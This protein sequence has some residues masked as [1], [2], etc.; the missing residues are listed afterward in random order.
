MKSK[1][2]LFIIT[3]LLGVTIATSFAGAPPAQTKAEKAT[4]TKAKAKPEETIPGAGVQPAAYFYT[5]KPYDE[6]LGG[7]VFTCR[8]Y[9]P[10]MNRWTTP[11]PSGFPDGANPFLY[12]PVPT[13]EFD[14]LGLYRQAYTGSKWVVAQDKTKGWTS[15]LGTSINPHFA[16]S[17]I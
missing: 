16:V 8:T 10:A 14:C 2:P 5:G 17:G 4:A 12:A 1:S 3:A 11:D 6:D 13:T 15:L 9:S 7:Y